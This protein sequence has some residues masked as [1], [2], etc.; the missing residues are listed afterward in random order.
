MKKLK[1]ILNHNW[2]ITIIGGVIV[3]I[4]SLII[5]PCIIKGEEGEEDETTENVIYRDNIVIVENDSILNFKDTIIAPPKKNPKKPQVN[6]FT[7]K[8]KIAHKYV[9]LYGANNIC[10]DGKAVFPKERNYYE[11]MPSDAIE[12]FIIENIE[13]GKHTFSIGDCQSNIN[14]KYNNQEVELICN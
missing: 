12:F 10:M 3:V 13:E 14:I 11:D 6:V 8:L 2:T 4:I 1:K 7:I 9:K 5:T